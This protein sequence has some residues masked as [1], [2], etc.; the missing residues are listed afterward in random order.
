MTD[1]TP[2]TAREFVGSML[3]SSIEGDRLAAE[4]I[5]E[6]RFMEAHSH[7]AVNGLVAGL[8]MEMLRRHDPQTADDLA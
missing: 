1:A 3:R 4:R 5:N 2:K 7:T 8:A 6:P